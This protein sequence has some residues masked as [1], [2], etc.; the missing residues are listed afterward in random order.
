VRTNTR[1]RTATLALVLALF[2]AACG[3]AAQDAADDVQSAAGEAESEATGGA[4]EEPSATPS[5]EPSEMAS[6]MGSEMASEMSGAMIDTTC[7]VEL[8]ADGEGSATGMADDAVGTAASNNPA[9]STLVTALTQANLVDTLNDT[10]QQYTVFAPTNDAFAKIPEADLQAVLADN[11]LLTS[12]LT[13]HVVPGE[14]LDAAAL[15]AAGSV[16]TVNGQELT[17]AADG[18]SL[19]V[20]GQ[21]AVICPNVMTANATVHLIDTVLMPQG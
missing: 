16:A 14:Q 4:S 11:D 5:E 2:A 20:N 21:A 10:S 19:N 1:L 15:A 12:I 18:G 9:L 8:P 3:G 6:E 13:L 17:L 7:Q